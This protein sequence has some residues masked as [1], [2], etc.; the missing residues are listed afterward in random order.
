M[1]SWPRGQ[2]DVAVLYIRN[3]FSRAKI[4]SELCI[5][6]SCTVIAR[7]FVERLKIKTVGLMLPF[8]D[9]KCVTTIELNGKAPSLDM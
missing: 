3:R 7:D 9:K 2:I 1:L 4:Q 6:T 5:Q 8:D